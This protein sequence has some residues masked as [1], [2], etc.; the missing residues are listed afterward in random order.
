M[1]T[2]NICLYK[3]VDK[4]YTG[5]N[6]KTVELLD[7]VLIGVCA[8]IRS[9]TV[10]KYNIIAFQTSSRQGGFIFCQ[11]YSLFSCFSTKTYY[12]YLFRVFSQGFK[13]RVPGTPLYG[14]TGFFMRF[15]SLLF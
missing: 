6:L 13:M 1:G 2:N 10:I 11:K 3:E 15:K 9:N 8:V 12:G 4:K 7:C 5:Y 14:I